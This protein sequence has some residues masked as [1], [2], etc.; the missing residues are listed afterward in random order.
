[1]PTVQMNTRINEKLKSAGDAAFESVGFTPTRAV[2]TLWEFAARNKH[3]REAIED[4]LHQLE[5]ESASEEEERK[6]KVRLAESGPGTFERF[7]EEMGVSE[8]PT[9]SEPDLSPSE[10]RE[11]A[12]LERAAQKGWIDG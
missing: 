6:R 3:D 1:M 2:R 10:I 12:A 8:M 11:R 5:G 4:L 9:F 7:L